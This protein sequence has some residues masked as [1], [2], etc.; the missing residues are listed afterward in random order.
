MTKSTYL[1]IITLNINGLNASIKRHRVA[2]WIR[3]QDP[4]AVYKRPTSEWKTHTYWNKRDGG[5]YFKQVEIKKYL[6]WQYL[7][8]IKY[9]WK[10]KLL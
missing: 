4:Y 5:R 10:A 7:Y 3:K 2:K 6:G 9:T 8:Q 1:S